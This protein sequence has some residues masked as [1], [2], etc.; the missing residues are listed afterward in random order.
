MMRSDTSCDVDGCE[1]QAKAGGYCSEHAQQDAQGA[2]RE[3]RLRVNKSKADRLESD[4]NFKLGEQLR[5]RMNFELSRVGISYKG[6]LTLIGCSVDQLR[7]Y[8]EH[9]YFQE[10]GN[11]WM[12]WEN[13]GGKRCNVNRS[14]ELDHIMPVSSF[15]LTDQEEVNKCFHWSNLQPLEWQKNMEKG[16]SIPKDFEW[17]Y[18]KERWM[19]SE[20]SGKINYELPPAGEEDSVQ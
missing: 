3:F 2:Y 19:W 16:D 13:W 4:L 5:K 6:K 9:N 11:E 17:C 18:V 10:E 15:D 20:A 8:F 14:W 7:Q 1:K 12:S